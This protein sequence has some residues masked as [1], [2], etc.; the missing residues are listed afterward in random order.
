M[1]AR[2]QTHL[3]GPGP[4]ARHELRGAPVSG[5]RNPND[6]RM[7]CPRTQT[8]AIRARDSP[9]AGHTARRT[10]RRAQAALRPF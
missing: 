7:P 3:V 1:P 6:G 4:D 2:G 5:E 8:S 10:Q 9:S